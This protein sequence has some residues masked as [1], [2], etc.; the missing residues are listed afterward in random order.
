MCL[1]GPGAVSVSTAGTS[2][3]ATSGAKDMKTKSTTRLWT[4]GQFYCE[5]TARPGQINSK[6]EV[7]F[8]PGR[9]SFT[10]KDWKT[11]C[12]E[13][14]ECTWR[15]NYT[16]GKASKTYSLTCKVNIHT[17]HSMRDR[18]A[19]DGDSPG[20]LVTIRDVTPAMMAS[21]CK[22]VSFRCTLQSLRQVSPPHTHSQTHA[23][24][25]RVFPMYST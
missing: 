8:T 10:P 4:H 21:L 25:T 14:R 6:S 3:G 16:Y 19:G 18:P 2:S 17:G 9:A 23:H 1:D 11:Y 22:W 15:Y 24:E 12:T 7:K 13:R 20:S 5:F